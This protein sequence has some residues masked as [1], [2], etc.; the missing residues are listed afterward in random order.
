MVAPQGIVILVGIVMSETPENTIPFS[1]G[2]HPIVCPNLEQHPLEELNHAQ[3]CQ[4]VGNV[5]L[6][7]VVLDD[8]R[9]RRWSQGRLFVQGRKS[10]N[11]EGGTRKR[12]NGGGIV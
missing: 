8:G 12:N 5:E 2:L 10:R 1:P 11:G 4:L 9:C 7:S 6:C 3:Q